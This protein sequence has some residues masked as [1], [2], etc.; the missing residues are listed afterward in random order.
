[1]PTL[2]NT[3]QGEVSIPYKRQNVQENATTMLVN[4]D[5]QYMPV[6][7]ERRVNKVMGHVKI[8]SAVRDTP[9]QITISKKEAEMLDPA[10]LE[11]MKRTVSLVS[12]K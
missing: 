12:D 11:M 5:G 10:A 3:S 1:M 4:L 8:P 9:G 2:I 7:R 6:E